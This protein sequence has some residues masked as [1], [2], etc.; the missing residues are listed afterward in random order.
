MWRHKLLLSN[1]NPPFLLLIIRILVDRFF[2][3][4]D[5]SKS[6]YERAAVLSY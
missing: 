4:V 6:K 2:E 3:N 5:V 1:A